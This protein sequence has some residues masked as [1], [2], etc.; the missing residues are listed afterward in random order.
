M[1]ACIIVASVGV[2]L[3]V[4]YLQQVPE[5]AMHMPYCFVATSLLSLAPQHSKPVNGHIHTV[6]QRT[7]AEAS[8]TGVHHWGI[9]GS[10]VGC[11]TGQQ[12]RG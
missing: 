1:L 8:K 2:F 5:L 3:H 11:R 12:G 7:S 9:K 4:H 10:V 6:C